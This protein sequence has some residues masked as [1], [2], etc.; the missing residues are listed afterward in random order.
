MTERKATTTTTRD[1]ILR[2]AARLRRAAM[3]LEAHARR[4]TEPEAPAH[5]TALRQAA[6]MVRSV[7]E[8]K[9]DH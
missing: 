9:V 3:L 5:E 7:I 2:A 1:A 8:R 6:G 4:C